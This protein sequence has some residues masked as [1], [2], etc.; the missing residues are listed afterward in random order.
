[1]IGRRV[2]WTGLIALPLM[3]TESPARLGTE[4]K[5]TD[6]GFVMRVAKS[7]KVRVYVWQEA[8]DRDAVTGTAA[9]ARVLRPSR[10]RRCG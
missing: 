6:A 8:G 1:M 10:I 2:A 7:P 4:M 5:L 3:A 9:E